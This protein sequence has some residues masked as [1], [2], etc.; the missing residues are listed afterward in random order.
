[1]LKILTTFRAVLM[2]GFQC[3]GR[4]WTPLTSPDRL[5]CDALYGITVR[6]SSLYC[7]PSQGLVQ[8]GDHITVTWTDVRR[9]GRLLYVVRSSSPNL[10]KKKLP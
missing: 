1:L 9:T 8:F 10:C 2:W 4:L 3:C 6:M 7:F 5:I